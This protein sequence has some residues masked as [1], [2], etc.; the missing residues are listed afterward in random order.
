MHQLWSVC[1]VVLK[2]F[3]RI[4]QR[5]KLSTMKEPSLQTDTW[6]L[7]YFN[8]VNYSIAVHI[9]VIICIMLSVTLCWN[10]KKEIVV[11]IPIFL[12]LFGPQNKVWK[13]NCKMFISPL[14]VC[15]EPRLYCTA[16]ARSVTLTLLW[17][18]D[19]IFKLSSY[20]LMRPQGGERE[21]PAVLSRPVESGSI[22]R[23]VF[24]N[25]GGG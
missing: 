24:I 2:C 20:A 7:T 5:F 6:W 25:Y 19:K 12:A 17:L 18:T 23:V 14:L 9:N 1:F 21:T 13:I 8:S 15:Q 4:S 22:S 16:L 3:R 10:T 11:I